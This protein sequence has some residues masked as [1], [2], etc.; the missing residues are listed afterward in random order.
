M[1]PYRVDQSGSEWGV[2]HSRTGHTA[3][4]SNTGPSK[5]ENPRFP[6]RQQSPSQRIASQKI[7]WVTVKRLCKR[8]AGSGWSSRTESTSASPHRQADDHVEKRREVERSQTIRRQTNLLC[9]KAPNDS[10]LPVFR[11]RKVSKRWMSGDEINGNVFE[12][13]SSKDVRR[14][15]DRFCKKAYA[16]FNA[17]H[18]LTPE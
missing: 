15:Q 3:H 13:H 9:V 2:T 17:H 16:L 8:I 1:S 5:T 11:S 4:R 7:R 12:G 6:N 18:W 14:S 10:R